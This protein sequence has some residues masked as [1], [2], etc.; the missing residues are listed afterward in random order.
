MCWQYCKYGCLCKVA[1]RHTPTVLCSQHEHFNQQTLQWCIIYMVVSANTD[2]CW[3]VLKG[4]N[5]QCYLEREIDKCR[6]TQ[7]HCNSCCKD[8]INSMYLM[9]KMFTKIY[10]SLALLV[11][12][13]KQ[14]TW[15]EK[16]RNVEKLSEADLKKGGG[17]LLRLW[18]YYTKVRQPFPLTN[19]KF[20]KLEETRNMLC[21]S[22]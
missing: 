5:G 7:S 1:W 17:L 21:S 6:V 20:C 14:K 11:E 9:V 18:R 3:L 12:M 13:Q 22:R 2:H 10:P 19:C 15:V 4:S 16:E 8:Q